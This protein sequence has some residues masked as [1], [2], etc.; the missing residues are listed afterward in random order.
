MV[1]GGCTSGSLGISV[2]LHI[3]S[4]VFSKGSYIQ[5]MGHIL[6]QRLY[7]TNYYPKPKYFVFCLALLGWRY[8]VR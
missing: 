7:Y 5:A 2:S 6:A 1:L 4:A 3:S 8:H